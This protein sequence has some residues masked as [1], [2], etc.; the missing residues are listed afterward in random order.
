MAILFQPEA[1]LDDGKYNS[2]DVAWLLV[3]T[4]LV[5]L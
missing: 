3:A 2:A 1:K 4:A 5:F